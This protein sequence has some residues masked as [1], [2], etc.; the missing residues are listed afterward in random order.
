MDSNH[1]SL[2][3]QGSALPLCYGAIVQLFCEWSRQ[4]LALYGARHLARLVAQWT[5]AMHNSQWIGPFQIF[6]LL[7]L[8][9]WPLHKAPVRSPAPKAFITRFI[10]LK[11][12]SPL[13]MVGDTGLEPARLSALEPK[14][15]ASANSANPP[16]MSPLIFDYRRNGTLKPP[17]T[18]VSSR[19]Y[20]VPLSASHRPTH[21][22]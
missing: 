6:V 18:M 4:P 7:S 10:R 9:M 14:S 16:Y 11:L 19:S 15:S 3:Y 21:H 8:S 5:G 20:E 17:R 1:R 12:H 2:P 13:S 22:L